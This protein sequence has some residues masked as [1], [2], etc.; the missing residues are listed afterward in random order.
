VA[1]KTLVFLALGAWFVAQSGL[2]LVVLVLAVARLRRLHTRPGAGRLLN[3][4]GAGLF[5]WLAVRVVNT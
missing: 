2:F 3:G 5:A 4:A 1:D